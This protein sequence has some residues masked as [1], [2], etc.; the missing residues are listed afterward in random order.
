MSH[1]VRAKILAVGFAVVAMVGCGDTKTTL[2]VTVATSV[3]LAKPSGDGY[4][5]KLVG[6]WE[7]KENLGDKEFKVTIEFTTDGSLKV[8]M[9]ELAMKGTYKVV[10]EEG[11]TVT[12]DTEMAFEGAPAQKKTMT[13][14]FEDADNI[15][16]SATDQPDPKKLKRKS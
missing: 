13:A 12:I 8:Q 14:I 5:K 2:K 6:V 7:G 4:S 3:T 9:D 10:K 11:K 1:A 16:M 15:T